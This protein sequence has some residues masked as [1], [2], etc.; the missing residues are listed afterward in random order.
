[1]DM[2]I[3]YNC[4]IKKALTEFYR[5]KRLKDGRKNTCKLCLFERNKEKRKLFYL[6]N[7]E[8]LLKKQNDYYKDY[9]EERKHYQKNRRKN[10]SEL[11]KALDRKR[12]HKD[13]EKSRKQRIKNYHKDVEKSRRV[14]REWVQ[15]NKEKAVLQDK[16]YKSS[17]RGRA[18]T[19]KRQREKLKNDVKFRLNNRIRARIHEVLKKKGKRKA[20]ST[21]KY[22]GVPNFDFL[23]K[24]LESKFKPGMNWKNNTVHG[25]HIDHIVPCA[26]FD[27]NEVEQQKKCWHYTNL[28]PLWAIDNM[29]KGSKIISGDITSPKT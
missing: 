16:K 13:V 23:K 26:S 9:R 27:F 5:D 12:Y 18:R 7:K 14:K 28:Q 24:Y 25:W 8:R 4:K 1:V 6:K 19:N 10:F 3:C 21:L 20:L 11:V 2:K 15:K 22:L 29:K 17:P